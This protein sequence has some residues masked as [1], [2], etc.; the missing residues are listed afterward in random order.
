MPG[1]F[2]QRPRR[3]AR[4]SNVEHGGVDERRERLAL[5]LNPEA[6][7]QRTHIQKATQTTTGVRADICRSVLA[8]TFTDQY[9]RDIRQAAADLIA[10]HPWL[11]IGSPLRGSVAS[12]WLAVPLAERCRLPPPVG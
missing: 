5:T 11:S 12:T 10:S 4:N 8:I 2:A 9:E 3:A 1:E 6:M 7:V